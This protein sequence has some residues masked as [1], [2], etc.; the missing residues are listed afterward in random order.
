MTFYEE[1]LETTK[2]PFKEI[3]SFDDLSIISLKHFQLFELRIRGHATQKPITI[4]NNKH[5]ILTNIF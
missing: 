5:F 1:I 4:N 3:F 2:V